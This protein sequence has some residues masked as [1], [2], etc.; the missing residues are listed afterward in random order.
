M[1]KTLLVR[2]ATQNGIF[3]SLFKERDTFVSSFD[4][5]F[6]DMLRTQFPDALQEMGASPIGRAAYPKVNVISNTDSIVIEAEL[7][8]FTKDNIDLDVNDGVLTISGKAVSHTENT[9]H[10]YIIREL[11]RSSFSRSFALGKELDASKVQASFENGLLSINIPK[12][13]KKES[14]PTKVT[15]K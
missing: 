3:N 1:K 7:A 13:V 6:D 12:F 9:E 2:P 11:K 10:V 14:I 5:I 15:I 8:G 4:Q